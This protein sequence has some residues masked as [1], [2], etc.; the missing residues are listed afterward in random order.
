MRIFVP[1]THR[2]PKKNRLSATAKLARKVEKIRAG[3]GKA[4][5]PPLYSYMGVP[6]YER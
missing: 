1:K 2:R 3:A 5:S 4:N 6:R